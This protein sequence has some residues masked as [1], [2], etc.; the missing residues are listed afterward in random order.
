MKKR[1]YWAGLL[2]LLTVVLLGLQN[3][4]AYEKRAVSRSSLRGKTYI[5]CEPVLVTGYDWAL[6]QDENGNAVHRPCAITGADPAEEL[7]LDYGFMAAGNRY[8]FYVT[9]RNE[10]FSRALGENVTEYTVSGWDIL[11]PIR[12]EWPHEN[13]LHPFGIV[14]QD[15]RDARG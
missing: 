10:Y 8:V 4:S 13:V 14:S 9:G 5:L 6:L 11:F 3:F 12:H 1:W 15:T 2:I 7:R